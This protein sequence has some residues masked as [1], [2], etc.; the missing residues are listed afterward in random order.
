M[1]PQPDDQRT[2]VISPFLDD[3]RLRSLARGR[4]DN[5]LISSEDAFATMPPST[6]RLFDVKTLDDTR[7]PADGLHAK[8]YVVHGAKTRRWIIGSANA[9]NA[10]ATRNAEL[11]VELETTTRGAGIDELLDYEDGIG[12]IVLD[13]VTPMSEEEMAE[14]PRHTRA[15]E[16]LRDLAASRLVAVV[17]ADEGQT[18]RMTI[19]LDRPVELADAVVNAAMANERWERL[20]PEGTPAVVLRRI[21]RTDLSPF[22]RVEVNADD[23]AHMRL[24]VMELDGVDLHELADQAM[25][26]LIGEDET[27]TPLEYLRRLLMGEETG[28][29]GLSF[30]DDDL[31]NP[32]DAGGLGQETKSSAARHALATAPML[33]TMLAALADD[34][35]RGRGAALLADV[36]SVVESFRDQLPARFLELWE[37]VQRVHGERT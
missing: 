3:R 14:A 19:S 15:E 6:L 9:T 32:E 18:Y 11:V 17:D 4:S 28:A 5:V 13:R 29:V 2:L 24:L 20:D 22:L 21:A 31:E 16:I 34:P 37:V 8:L 33:E 25:A 12:S 36:T 23:D 35:T 30:D 7:T 10:A 1:A 27:L 26:D